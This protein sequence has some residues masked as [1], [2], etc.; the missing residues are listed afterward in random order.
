MKSEK[1]IGR[2]KNDTN[3]VTLQNVTKM[4]HKYKIKF[5]FV[6]IKKQKIS[7]QRVRLVNLTE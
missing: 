3:Q 7:L 2:H 1:N 4:S 6:K 5:I